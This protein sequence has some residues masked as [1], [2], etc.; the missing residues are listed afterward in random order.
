MG[1]AINRRTFIK[2]ASAAG[3]GT[4]AVA[5]SLFSRRAD[6]SATFPVQPGDVVTRTPTYCEICF[7]NCAG[8]AYAKNGAPWKIVGNDED[9]H[10]N[11]RFCTRGT[12]GIGAYTDP[13]RLKRPLIRVEER[14][15]QVFR[16][17]SWDEAL[18]YI[19][20]RLADIKE[21]HGPESLA[22]FSHGSGATH[23]KTLVKAYGSACITAPSYAQCRGPRD[24]GFY[25]TF[26]EEVGSP[27]RTDIENSRCMVLVG[28]HLGENLH[29]GQVQ[30]MSRFLE[31][32]GE[33]IVVDPRFSTAAGK[34]K[35]WLPIK[36]ATDLALL[37][38]W[39]HVILDEELYDKDYVARY[40][41]GLDE[42]KSA[43][44]TNTPEWAYPITTLAPEV[45]RETA[46]LMARHAPATL[47]HPGRHAT[48]Y[49]DDTQRSRAVAILNALLG[50]WG[51]P[52]GFY[53][54][55]A[56]HVPE[57]EHPPFPQPSWQLCDY[58]RRKYPFAMSTIASAIRDAS[59]EPV[60]EGRQVKAWLVYGSNLIF[61]LPDIERT[62]EA[63]QHLELL[64]AVDIM[65]A[66]ICGWADVVLPEAT[67]LERYDDLRE[68]I[69]RQPQ[70]A[71]RAPAFEP[72]YDAKPS[73]WIV[74]RLAEKMGLGDYFPW[75]DQ[76]DYLERRLRAAGSSLD[77]MERV[78]VKTLPG[79][80]PLYFL[81]GEDVRFGTPSGKIELYAQQLADAGF[82]PVPRYTPHPEPPDGY[83]RLLSGR[84]PFHTFAR[85]TN[86]PL[87]TELMAENELWIHPSVARDWGIRHGQYVKMRNQDDRVSTFPIRARLTERIRPDCVYMVHG[88]GHQAKAMQRSF[89][90]GA[91]DN[92]LLTNVSVDP[93]MGGTGRRQNFVTFVLET[94]AAGETV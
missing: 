72:M 50:S 2:I 30:E 42:L 73:D 4:L 94:E 16:E 56:P 76:R 85:T 6:A 65:P 66:E 91:D 44:A 41:T 79:A 26:G 11:G 23:W 40:A 37:L 45:I 19:A 69:G 43:V 47:V 90:K 61:A 22:M 55:Q 84:S 9:Q 92:E 8:W 28:S 27:E 31:R 52:G 59:I 21:K 25:L 15:R 48:W 83:Y 34:A 63:I 60:A 49:G 38:A 81:P 1:H 32:G 18:D 14:G 12:G 39:I 78:G 88:F 68:A 75:D 71:L 80:G 77:E 87:L 93:I 57:V 58:V 53:T 35:H 51:R 54:P 46:R 3:V 10:S 89:G 24:T 7:W 33:L 70:I 17:V 82:D 13:E 64:V 29:N 86:N 20:V 62:I 36:P 5:P 74:K 67:Y